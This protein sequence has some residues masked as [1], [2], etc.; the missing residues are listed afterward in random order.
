MCPP[1]PEHRCW[2]A[3]FA[4]DGEV[5]L[6]RGTGVPEL[7]EAITG[8]VLAVAELVGRYATPARLP[9]LAAG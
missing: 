9:D 6:P 4:V 2:F 5:D 8:H 3:L 1:G 7:Y